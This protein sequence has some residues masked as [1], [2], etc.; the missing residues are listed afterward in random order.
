MTRFFLSF[1][2]LAVAFAQGPGMG[3]GPRAAAGQPPANALKTY[4]S[5]TDAQV[6]SFKQIA[7]QT[8]T[9]VQPLMQQISTKSKALQ[10]LRRQ[11]SSDTTALGNLVVEIDGLHK[12]V[13]DARASALT[14]V[15]ALLTADQKTKLTALEAAAQLMP[16]IHEAAALGLI[17]APAGGG[18]MGGRM[19]MG[20]MGMGGP[21][22]GRMMRGL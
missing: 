14:Q 16:A 3:P 19:G 4:L 15:Q 7:Q 21:G 20:P 8:R 12:Q 17:Q 5:L 2:A 18:G 1:A 6:Q 22:A 9:T 11:G 10:D 13:A